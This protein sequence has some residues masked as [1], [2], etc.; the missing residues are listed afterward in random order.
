VR[1]PGKNGARSSRLPA[2][3]G[4]LQRHHS[5]RWQAQPKAPKATARSR[6]VPQQGSPEGQAA[7]RPAASSSLRKR[8]SIGPRCGSPQNWVEARESLAPHSPGACHRAAAD[9]NRFAGQARGQAQRR[10]PSQASRTRKIA[11]QQAR[12]S[13]WP[14]PRPTALLSSSRAWRQSC[15]EPPGSA[16][17]RFGSA[18]LGTQQAQ[19]EAAP[20]QQWTHRS[21][22][23]RRAGPGVR[24]GRRALQTR[25]GAL[26]WTGA[27]K[28]AT[29]HEV[30]SSAGASRTSHSRWTSPGAVG[31]SCRPGSN[32]PHRQCNQAACSD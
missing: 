3:A 23:R 6:R 26:A 20:W 24:S 8:R 21:M 19:P 15:D 10:P 1:R 9:A 11:G 14:S 5:R 7:T 17:L 29:G 4:G 25:S 12:A 22:A 28:Q 32:A 2:A 31:A 30:E 27:L 13:R 16:Q 18:P